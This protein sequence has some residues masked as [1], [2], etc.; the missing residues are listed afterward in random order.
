MQNQL[1]FPAKRKAFRDKKMFPGILS[2]GFLFLFFLMPSSPKAQNLPT[3]CNTPLV[4]NG[5]VI[6]KLPG[7]ILKVL[8]GSSSTLNNLVDGD[9]NT[10]ATFTT[11]A[12]LGNIPLV[13]IKDMLRY[14]PAGTRAGFVVQTGGSILDVSLLSGFTINTYRNGVLQ[15]TVTSSNST[16]AVELIGNTDRKQRISFIT[17]KEFDE[18]EITQTSLL[19]LITSI[20]IYYAFVEP[21]GGCN[22]DCI[23]PITTANYPAAT[24][25]AS[26]SGL[27]T[28]SGC[29]ANDLTNLTDNTL[30]N[31]A[32]MYLILGVGGWESISVKA[33]TTIPAGSDAGF[34]MNTPSG[35]LDV[36]LL[37]NT[38][39]STYLSG[40]LQE[41]KTLGSV[42][43]ISILS[44]G[45]QQALSFTTTKTFDE[46]R[47]T[48][49]S[50]VSLVKTYQVYYAFIRKDSDGD[51]MPDCVDKCPGGSD[52]MDSNG[53]GIPDACDTP[54]TLNLGP[55]IYLC[56]QATSYDFSTLGLGTG[57][58]W[59]IPSGA[60]I[61]T[62]GVITGMNT[63]GTYSVRVNNTAGCSDTVAIIK[64]DPVKNLLCNVP[65]TGTGVEIFDP[66]GGGCL[67]CLNTGTSEDP[68]NVIDGNLSNFITTGS[69]ASILSSTPV[70]GVRNTRTTYPAGTRTGFAVK[71][72]DGLLNVSL[73]SNISIQ[74]YMNGTLVE[75]ISGSS[76]VLSAEV[77]SGD[78]SLQRIGFVTSQP[79]NGVALFVNGAVLISSGL[80]VYYAFQESGT[81]CGN[82][83]PDDCTQLLT[84]TNNFKAQLEMS[85][86][87]YSGIACALCSITNLSNAID[88]DAN[89]FATISQTVG[90]ETTSSISIKTGQPIT[91][92][93]QTGFI[94]SS[95][96]G[97]LTANVLS[98][99][100]VQTYNNGTL[101]NNYVANNSLVKL[102]VLNAS[103]GKIMVSFTPT[104]SF[105]EIRLSITSL[106]SVAQSVYV[107]GAFVLADSDG[108]GVPD[109]IDKC[110]AGPDSDVDPNGNGTPSACSLN[111]TQDAS[112][113]QSPVNI[114]ISGAG[115][116][117]T[118]TYTLS[119]GSTTIGTF[120]AGNLI[121]NPASSGL[122]YYSIIM[123]NG[124]FSAPVKSMDLNIHPRSAVWTPV[125]N[126]TVWSN[127]ANWKPDSPDTGTGSAPYWCTDVTIPGDASSFPVLESGDQCRDIYF[128]NNASVGKIVS[129]KYRHAY[130]EFNPVRNTWIMTSA[131]LRYMYSADYGADYS[132]SNAMS[133][134]VFMRYFD[135]Q[136]KTS[137]RT[138][139]DGVRGTSNG[140]FSRAFAKLD[141][142]LQPSSGFAIWVNGQPYDDS[143]FAAPQAYQFPRRDSNGDDV[144]YSMHDIDGNW[145]GSPFYMPQRGNDIKT[146][147]AWTA[148]SVPD[149]NNRYRF[150]YESLLDANNEFYFSVEKGTTVIVGNP[151]MSHLDFNRL[152]DENS[153]LIYNYY[154]IWNGSQFYTYIYGSGT[155]VWTGLD[156]LTSSSETSVNQYI[157]PMQ[158][159]FVETKPEAPSA[160][161]KF[162]PQC[163]VSK[164][165]STLRSYTPGNPQILRISV[166][167]G[168]QEG[169]SI[170][171]A[172]PD[173]SNDY[174]PGED[175]YKLFSP[176]DDVPEIYTVVN[177]NAMEINAV[178]SDH[179][180]HLI[181]IGIKTTQT[182]SMSL[183][184]NGGETFSSYDEV[185]IVDLYNNE[186]YDLT[187][188]ASISF[189]KS[190]SENIE[191]RFYISLRKSSIA[192]NIEDSDC[193][194]LSIFISNNKN[195]I[196]VSSPVE[197]IQK[198]LVYDIS[199]KLK[200]S[201]QGTNEHYQ[202]LYIKETQGVY[203][204]QVKTGTSSKNYKLVL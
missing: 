94:L 87:G 185:K 58:T 46:I 74:T 129:L 196:T 66:S 28:C 7:N 156:G 104:A 166:K 200:Y 176:F 201:K 158:A 165:G 120:N 137:G 37:Q 183:N 173:A 73:L 65:I 113:W 8:P 39:I 142:Y 150:S 5:R 9:L 121:I 85:R 18:I 75:N 14:Y 109:C 80:R 71:S 160:N 97:L 13:S 69:L 51:G 4:G 164:T 108:D 155:S 88:G 31:F 93:Y 127:G 117:A 144:M 126:D 98:S 53:N 57:L 52:Y 130:V 101:V 103:S 145:V 184:I 204:L 170:V 99:I 123:Q 110:C 12:S 199:G 198:I 25:S 152:Y 59:S 96:T 105:N 43:N 19:S 2:A 102:N 186:E 55:D 190:L 139:P 182:G 180:F 153:S 172:L 83:A 187:Q 203:I 162:T 68:Q 40:T 119:D 17:T 34:V 86:T 35:L 60:S 169:H 32:T 195:F 72:L 16:L 45:Q 107:H 56:A 168:D 177:E 26:N 78:K 115:Y 82:T 135:V 197:C 134:K 6:N 114:G 141:E 44:G 122:K 136:Y 124:S 76:L 140:N 174:V 118:N 179:D 171:A 54:C 112:C 62:A 30:T 47:L 84:A 178:N 64:R 163:S 67:I 77:I 70:I 161:L 1:D 181:P 132:W 116:S 125:S 131:P 151:F 3:R 192:T 149:K 63:P 22:Y 21:S 148:T 42:A 95:P 81:N 138:N 61:S 111:V 89:T 38:T 48:E 191:G 20:N 36:S 188:T 79:F 175:I 128:K 10:Y 100:T 23:T 29:Y 24:A 193:K 106:A 33:G 167:A 11:A 90:A 157:S 133:P 27:L 159:F 41:S 202:Q 92:G 189:K 154:R 146:E 147:N 49:G 143:N 50:L 91:T 15:E 194:N